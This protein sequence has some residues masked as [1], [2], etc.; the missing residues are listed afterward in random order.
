MHADVNLV[1]EQLQLLVT[2]LQDK[3]DRVSTMAKDIHEQFPGDVGIFCIYFL[4]LITLNPGQ[5]VFLAANE[6]H[7]YLKYVK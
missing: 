2:R 7:A 4:N 3:T 1:K 5:G 6:P